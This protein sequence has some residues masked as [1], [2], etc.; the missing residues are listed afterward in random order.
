M[1]VMVG[2][3][4]LLLLVLG[5][6]LIVRGLRGRAVDDHPICRRCGFDLTGRPEGVTICS[7]QEREGAAPAA[8]GARF[9]AGR[10]GFGPDYSAAKIHCSRL[11]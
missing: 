11:K 1:E 6:L 2:L 10:G 4:P 3:L 8:G 9:T 5:V 7:E